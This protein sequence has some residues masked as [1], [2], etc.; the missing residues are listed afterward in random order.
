MDTLFYH[1]SNPNPTTWYGFA[2]KIFAF[3]QEAGIPQV[4]QKL[5]PIPTSEFPL[6]AQ[7][8]SY[9]VMDCTSTW[10]TFE[11][12]PKDWQEELRSVIFHLKELGID[13]QEHLPPHRRVPKS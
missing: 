7:R 13:H 1:L 11:I 3:G 5:I 8:P 9:S 10:D 4:L 2:Q 6:K 12:Q